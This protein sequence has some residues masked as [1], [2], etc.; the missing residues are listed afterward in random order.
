MDGDT[1]GEDD[2]ASVGDVVGDIVGDMVG[3][4]VLVVHSTL[5][6]SSHSISCLHTS[7][8]HAAYS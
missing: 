6:E 7:S 3:D 5:C 2:G 1:D 4:G 8:P